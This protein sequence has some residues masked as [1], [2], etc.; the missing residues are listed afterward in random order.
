MTLVSLSGAFSHGD[1]E[2]SVT[3]AVRAGI[4]TDPVHGAV[5]PPTVLSSNFT[6]RRFG[7]KRRFDYSRSGNPTRALL[8]ETL[9]RLEGGAGA[10]CVASGMAAATLVAHWLG[11]NRRL[12]ASHDLYGG[13]H[14]LFCALRDRGVLDVTFVDFTD[15]SSWRP[16]VAAGCA[17]VWVETPSNPLLRV[18][19]VDAVATAAHDAGAKVVVD[20]TFLSPVN[21]RPIDLGADFVVHSTTKSINGHSDVVGGA[22]VAACPDDAEALDHWCNCLGLSQS[23]ADCA[24]ILRGARTLHARWACHERNAR[25]VATLLEAHP[26]V[27]RVHYPGLATSP[28]HALASRQQRGFG[29]VVSFDLHAAGKAT[30][31]TFF[32]RLQLF[33]LAESLGGVESL[34]AHPA[35]MTHLSMTPAAREAAGIGPSLIRLSVGIE[36]P[37]DLLADLQS[38]LDAV[39]HE[40][41]VDGRGKAPAMACPPPRRER[42]HGAWAPLS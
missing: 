38:A 18:T 34:A 30:L 42:D 21:Q 39:G 11:P 14:R 7:E 4:A 28:Y 25:A 3:T 23:P 13:C 33:S 2:A 16:A 5:V 29:S 41:A 8:E 6:F 10:V 20:N 26:A 27:A 22:V 35:T 17:L 15:P 37:E 32:E 36:A 31:A 24:Q 12:L 40:S 9:A 1:T 19:D